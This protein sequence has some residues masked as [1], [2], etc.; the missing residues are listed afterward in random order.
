M[1]ALTNPVTVVPRDPRPSDAP[2]ASRYDPPVQDDAGRPMSDGNDGV[3]R[4]QIPALARYLRLARLTAAG[5]AGDLGF[6]LDTLEDIRVAVDELC[7]AIIYGTPAGAE[8]ELIYRELD[9]GLVI[10]GRCVALT[11]NPPVL[12]LVARE[13]LTILADEYSIDAAGRD[14]S[15][16]LVKLAVS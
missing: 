3:I 5:M 11:E 1:T 14:R 6:N 13:L 7:A 8:L 4:L 16:R 2:G 10:E 15:F 12:H 9:G